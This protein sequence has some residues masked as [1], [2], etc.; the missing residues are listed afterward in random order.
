M[1]VPP[2]PAR[3]YFDSLSC[4]FLAAE[5]NFAISSQNQI[6]AVIGKVYSMKHLS[7]AGACVC[8]AEDFALSLL[9]CHYPHVLI[10]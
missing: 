3:I 4:A 2:R 1:S 7:R 8:V 5:T 10:M 9:V 6:M